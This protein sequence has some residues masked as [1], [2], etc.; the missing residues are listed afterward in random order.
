MLEKVDFR[1]AKLVK[2][3]AK[4][5]RRW[6]NFTIPFWQKITEEQNVLL[7]IGERKLS[8]EIKTIVVEKISSSLTH[9]EKCCVVGGKQ[10][11]FTRFTTSNMLLHIVLEA[12]SRKPLTTFDICFESPEKAGSG[13]NV[14]QSLISG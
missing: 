12:W 6:D 13:G 1:A 2:S 11:F 10:R 4:L 7:T 8:Q 3:S 9:R 5:S 14:K